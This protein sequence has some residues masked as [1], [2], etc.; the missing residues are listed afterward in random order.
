[1]PGPSTTRPPTAVP[2][3]MP[4]LNE[5]GSSELARV[6]ALGHL[7]FAVCM[8]MEMHGTD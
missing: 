4:T 2:N 5:T 7:E 6:S 1:M 3:A 8:N